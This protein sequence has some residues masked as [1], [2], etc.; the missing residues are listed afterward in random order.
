[1]RSESHESR[2]AEVILEAEI[3]KEGEEARKRENAAQQRETEHLTEIT[4]LKETLSER[5]KVHAQEKTLLKDELRRVRGP[6]YILPSFRN[7]DSTGKIME[8]KEEEH[9][10]AYTANIK[11]KDSTLAALAGEIRQLKAELEAQRVSSEQ[12]RAVIET[13]EENAVNEAHQKD[14]TAE[15]TAKVSVHMGLCIYMWVCG[16]IC[17]RAL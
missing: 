10:K 1:M 5:E 11:A 6:T 8:S 14:I 2:K 4:A 3:L 17:L 7:R 9:E 13:L 12:Q 16:V 15:K